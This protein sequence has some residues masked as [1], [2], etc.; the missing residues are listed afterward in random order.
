VYEFDKDLADTWKR[1]AT[2]FNELMELKSS[3]SQKRVSENNKTA[4]IIEEVGIT[5]N[6]ALTRTLNRPAEERKRPRLSRTNLNALLLSEDQERKDEAQT[7]LEVCWIVVLLLLLMLVL[8]L[9]IC[10]F[11][12]S[13]LGISGRS[14]HGGWSGANGRPRRV[15]ECESRR[16]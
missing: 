14:K 3:K 7:W 12:I 15:G 13:F 1:I 16:R 6:Q 4:S 8:L 5:R 10:F 9:I 11:G 2:E